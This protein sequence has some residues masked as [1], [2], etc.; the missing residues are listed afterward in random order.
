MLRK[1]MRQRGFTLVELIVAIAVLA[2]V[3][4]VS[5]PSIGTWM[6]NTRI[7]NV[8]DALQNGIQIAKAEAVRRNENVSFFLV[9]LDNPSLLSND[10]ALSSTSGSWVVSVEAPTSHC[11]DAPS[12]ESS[13]KIVTGRAVGNGGSNVLVASVRSDDTTAATTITFNGFGRLTNTD[14]IAK[15]SVTGPTTGVEYRHLQIRVTPAGQVRMCDPRIT[16][17]TDPRKC[18]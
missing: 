17:V 14:A 12:T 10:C 2:L 8:A 5:M 1:A 3:L 7:R 13:P 11:G 15:I 9:S 4:A 16:T 18:P 6:D